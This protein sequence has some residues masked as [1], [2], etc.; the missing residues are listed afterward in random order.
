MFIPVLV[1]ESSS[2]VSSCIT[3]WL[4]RVVSKYFIV[5]SWCLSECSIYNLMVDKLHDILSSDNF[6]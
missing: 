4:V 2:R 5:Y 6:I 1:D 3:T